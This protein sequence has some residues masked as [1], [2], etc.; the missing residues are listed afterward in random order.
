[1]PTDVL[2]IEAGTLTASLEDRTVTG[3]LLPYGETGRTNLGRVSVSPG[4]VELPEDVST[5]VA[6]LEHN[7]ERPVASTAALRDTPDGIVA[8]FRVGKGRDGD[9]LLARIE[10][11]REAGNPMRLSAEVRDIVIRAGRIVSGALFGGAFTEEGAFPSAAL[12][13]SDV[14]DAPAHDAEDVSESDNVHQ[15][16]TQGKDAIMADTLTA[17]DATPDAAPDA[18][19]AIPGASLMAARPPEPEAPKPATFEQVIHALSMYAK[20]GDT[21]GLDALE[22]ADKDNA[23]TLFAALTDVKYTTGAGVAVQQPQW[24]GNVWSG[25]S[26]TRRYTPLFQSRPL[27]SFKVNGYR[28]TT[29]PA[30]GAWTGD[31]TAVPS[32]TIATEAV[33]ENAKRWAGGNDLA[34]EFWDFNEDG[35][36][37]D[38]IR[39]LFE[40][41]ARYSDQTFLSDLVAGATNVNAG[42]VPSGANPATVSIVDG[43]LAVLDADAVPASAIC[44]PD[45][46]RELLLQN[47]DDVIAT[48]SLSLG[49]EEGSLET[50]RIVPAKT[51]LLT[52]GTVL[53]SSQD[54][55][56]FYE[57]PGVPIRTTALDMI[58]AGV[59]EVAFGYF[60]D[61][62]N[63]SGAAV[64]V[65]KNGVALPGA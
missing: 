45:I 10:E 12:L 28:W 59:D 44:A 9:T 17:P 16:E 13:A 22:A 36:L 52:A 47:R 65:Y 34:R 6:N 53:V 35:F 25:R 1:M 26:Y 64:M 49:L 43:S 30:G 60:G 58:K 40:D 37:A 57:M 7:R 31:K 27:T 3:L 51:G 42:T 38:Y 24:V 2:E 41:Y 19:A 48:L 18:P 4:A 55:A 11:R 39:L 61:V 8:T 32:N 33:T 46:Y 54:A 63:N 29:K 23:S 50:F 56:T 15:D 14:G 62:V 20:T 21:S 5:M